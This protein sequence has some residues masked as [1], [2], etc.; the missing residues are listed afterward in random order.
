MELEFDR[1]QLRGYD[2]VLDTTLSQEE[3]LESIVP[4]SFPDVQ[5]ILDCC[6][7]IC[8]SKKQAREGSISVSG[9]IRAVILYQPDGD[10]SGLQRMEVSLPFT[11]Q[12]DARGMT[13]DGA[14]LASPRL[15]QIEARALN[16]RKLLLRADLAI[17]LMACQP[18]SQVV[19][20][21]VIDSESYGVCQWTEQLDTY[22]LSAVQERPFLFS[23]QIRLPGAGGEV[24]I[25]AYRAVA[26]CS[27]SKLIGSK[28]ILKGSVDL[29]VLMQEADRT[30]TSHREAL[31]FS[32]VM[33][34]SGLGMEGDCQVWTDLTELTLSASSEDSRNVEVS[35]EVLAQAMVWVH[36]SVPV[37]Q[38]LY[39]T[40]WTT[41]V[42]MGQQPMYQLAEQ[43]VRPQNVR[44]L[45]EIGSLVRS[46]VASH[47]DLGEMT[48]SREGEQ[49]VL[50]VQPTLT[51]LY[52]G[53]QEQL[54]SVQRPLSAVCR[55]D[56]PEG[57]MFHGRCLCPGEVFA[58]PAAGGIEVRFTLEFHCMAVLPRMVPAVLSARVGEARSNDGLQPSVVL[59]MAE[60][61][62]TLWDIAKA[63]GTTR[64]QIIQ[65]NELE[66]DAPMPHTML[67]IPRGR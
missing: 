34:I 13:E 27:E 11:G 66:P 44:E 2:V 5:Q 48:R 30:L 28:L 57:A 25:L 60:P 65:A 18:S 46:V 59:R 37:L 63:Y 36:R 40:G 56:C 49:L 31:P 64:Q 39:S 23:E 12:A 32:Q 7:Q 43:S 9:M 53:D 55:L 17:D 8:L 41:E 54:M 16:P 51:V 21:E 47:L 19:C 33:E 38:D 29:Q 67:L 6:G 4:D 45:L 61:E 22:L 58:A 10:E 26:F 15:H 52:L 42:Q 1:E 24:R 35:V 50:T 3:T 20:G 14:V 62:E